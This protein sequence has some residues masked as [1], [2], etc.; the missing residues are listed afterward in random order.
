VSTKNADS[1]DP[2][3][4]AVGTEAFEV[5]WSQTN[6]ANY[7]INTSRSAVLAVSWS[8][9]APV[10]AAGEDA[11]SAQ[12]AVD[13]AGNVSAI[14]DWGDQS[15]KIYQIQTS[16]EPTGTYTWSTPTTLSDPSHDTKY[17]RLVA[18]A[19]GDLI[20]AWTQSDG[21]NYLASAAVSPAGGSGWGSA[22]AISATGQDAKSPS[23]A[24]S[25]EGN[26][27]LVWGRNDGTW[28][29][30][31]TSR[32][33]LAPPLTWMLGQKTAFPTSTDFPVTWSSSDW[34]GGGSFSL[35]V[36][37]APWDGTFT[38]DT[39]WAP[40]SITMP[41]TDHWTATYTGQPGETD[42]FSVQ[43]TDGLGYTGAWS[44]QKCVSVP[45]DDTT[46]TTSAGWQHLSRPGTYQG[47]ITAS[48]TKGATLTF[49]N[50]RGKS[51]RILVTEKVDGGKFQLSFNGKDLGTFNTAASAANKLM[52]TKVRKSLKKDKTGDLVITVLGTG[53]VRVDGVYVIK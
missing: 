33:D 35:Q 50:A 31:Q 30:I 23:L 36:D 48:S 24:T 2:S 49:P 17:P 14:W 1:G 21:S 4:V 45:I 5:A 7:V 26:V 46:G 19:R 52:L 28:D 20:A 41:K 9:A 44:K 22:K 51:F 15:S 13:Q 27:A 18:D 38:G 32:Y 53:V 12:L 34:T 16:T 8:A 6:G 39:A 10:S 25:A 3:L 47:T 11:Y 43:A 42:C 40:G 29:R 37:T